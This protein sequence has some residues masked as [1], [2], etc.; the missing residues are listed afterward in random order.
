MQRRRRRPFHGARGDL[1]THATQLYRTNLHG[2]GKVGKGLL[3][4]SPLALTVDNQTP[5]ATL[6]LGLAVAVGWTTR[7]SCAR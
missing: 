1:A 7:E 3:A 2:H 5:I 4:H 6:A